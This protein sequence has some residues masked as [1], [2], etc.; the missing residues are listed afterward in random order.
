MLGFVYFFLFQKKGEGQQFVSIKKWSSR[1]IINSSILV[2]VLY[3]LEFFYAGNIPFI[4]MVLGNSQPGDYLEFGIPT[5]HVI[6]VALS[7]LMLSVHLNRMYEEKNSMHL[8]FVLSVLVCD[9]LTLSRGL[10]IFSIMIWG[11]IKLHYIKIIKFRHLIIFCCFFVAFSYLFGFVGQYRSAYGDPDY[12]EQIL[13]ASEEFK[14]SETPT[15]YLWLYIYTTSPLANLQ[16]AINRNHE[17]LDDF[18][19]FFVRCL[20]HQIIS[21]RIMNL[22]D[23]HFPLIAPNL[24][25]GTVYYYSYNY[26]GYFGLIFTYLYLVFMLFLIPLVSKGTVYFVPISS[27]LNALV[28]LSVFDNMFIT[29]FSLALF[30]S[31]FILISRRFLRFFKESFQGY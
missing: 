23:E 3:G 21:K 1:K 6:I 17:Q 9:M 8:I 12:A 15:P 30:L 29:G 31:F 5:I 20:T 10:F 26:L 14:K 27:M 22:D 25:V 7:H 18:S 2:F 24:T 19:D 16:H 4:A 28:F 13:G 11:F